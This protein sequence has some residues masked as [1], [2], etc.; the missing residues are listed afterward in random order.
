MISAA[1]GKT[2]AAHADCS[3]AFELVCSVM[4]DDHAFMIWMAF[5][6]WAVSPVYAQ[7]SACV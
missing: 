4:V 3:G 6:A 5:C 1:R 7:S 2:S